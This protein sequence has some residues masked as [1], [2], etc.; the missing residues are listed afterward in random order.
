MPPQRSRLIRGRIITDYSQVS[1]RSAPRKTAVGIIGLHGI[2]LFGADAVCLHHKFITA[3]FSYIESIQ[4]VRHFPVFPC[5]R[6]LRGV[7]ARPFA[8]RHEHGLV[9]VAG[10]VAD[11]SSCIR[12]PFPPEPPPARIFSVFGVSTTKGWLF[13]PMP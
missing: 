9:I 3:R 1:V 11:L 8:E 5:G 7:R 4:R 12:A 13:P 2:A 6:F 10:R